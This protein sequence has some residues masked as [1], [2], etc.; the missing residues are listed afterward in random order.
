MA[1]LETR[2]RGLNRDVRDHLLR[3]MLTRGGNDDV[4]DVGN[5]EESP[6]VPHEHEIGIQISTCKSNRI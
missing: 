1:N 2:A 6:A 3:C 4:V 5:A